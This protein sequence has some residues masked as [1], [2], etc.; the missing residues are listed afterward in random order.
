MFLVKTVL[1]EMLKQFKQSSAAASAL[2]TTTESLS[3]QQQQQQ[4]NDDD[5]SQYLF[6]STSVR[7][8]TVEVVEN[9][10]KIA[11]ELIALAKMEPY[12]EI[13][14]NRNDDLAEALQQLPNTI[15]GSDS[16]VA[17]INPSIN[18][19]PI[20]MVD[21][22]FLD[23]DKSRYLSDLQCLERLS[24]VSSSA[25]STTTTPTSSIR[26]IHQ[27][28]YVAADNVIFAQI[29]DYRDYLQHLA[30]LGIVQTRCQDG[31]YLEYSHDEDVTGSGATTGNNNNNN[32][33]NA[34][35]K[36]MPT[37]QPPPEILYR[38]GIELTVYLL[39]PPF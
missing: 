33:R 28:T 3:V 20:P 30:Q 5:D 37:C 9:H 31:L 25:S 29:N 34:S 12:I 16:D 15:L 11:K 4:Q 23:H 27:G 6:R 36:N 1:K 18:T 38:D 7:L 10:A 2:T 19:T 17:C 26:L 13:I 39:D 35:D 14:V 24:A 32:N 21:F 8:V 22:I